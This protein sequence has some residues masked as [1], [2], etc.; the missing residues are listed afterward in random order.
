MVLPI[1]FLAFAIFFIVKKQYKELYYLLGVF[2]CIVI[3]FLGAYLL[4]SRVSTFEGARGFAYIFA[5]LVVGI[6]S[7]FIWA[8]LHRKFKTRT[9]FYVRSSKI[10]GIINFIVILLCIVLFL[11][12]K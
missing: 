5:L 10:L 7:V 6:I 2:A 1:L 4:T 11:I 12:L 9:N 8:V 3:S